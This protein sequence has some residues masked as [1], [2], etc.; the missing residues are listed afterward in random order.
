MKRKN[1]EILRIIIALIPLITAIS[2]IFLTI[3]CIN[4]GSIILAILFDLILIGTAYT[5]YVWFNSYTD[6][7][8]NTYKNLENQ[9]R[10]IEI[11]SNLENG[12]SCNKYTDNYVDDVYEESKESVS[13]Y[14]P[15]RRN[16]NYHTR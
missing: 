9:E 15:R 5:M 7:I 6:I 3:A 12:N 4:A 2:C 10:I 8:E 11:L 13:D 14:S 1:Y 16:V